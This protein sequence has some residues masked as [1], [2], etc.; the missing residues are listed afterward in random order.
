MA[1]QQTT[2]AAVPVGPPVRPRGVLAGAAPAPEGWELG[3]ISVSQLCPDPVMLD[4]CIT[5]S[6]EDAATRPGRFEFPAFSIEQGS[7]C[8][9]MGFGDRSREAREALDSITDAALGMA[10]SSPTF[11]TDAPSL[12]DATDEGSFTS[13]AAALAA[14]ETAASNTGKGQLYVIHATPAAAI[15]MAAAGVLSDAGVTP[16]GAAVIVSAGYVSSDGDARIWAT[17]RVWASVGDIAVREAVA[18]RM[19]NREAWASRNAIVGFNPCI[20]LTA[21]IADQDQP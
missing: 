17:G 4:K 6:G 9:T 15:L 14:L 8:S 18:R 10:L 21:S 20:N 11:N 7:G 5:F 13:P 19:N 1:L 16:T 3:G 12:A 2:P